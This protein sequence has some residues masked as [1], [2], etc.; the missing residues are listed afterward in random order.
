MKKILLIGDSVRM[1]YD[2]YVR[3]R[4]KGLAEVC[5]PPEN[6]RFTTYILRDLHNWTDALELYEADAVHWNAGLWDTLRIYGD[7]NLV[8][9]ETYAENID[10]I[11]RRIEFLFPTARQIF[12]TST[13]VIEEGYIPGFESRT[14]ADIETY[15]EIACRVLSGRAAINDLYAYL[16]DCHRDLHSDQTHFY[17]KEGTVLIGDRVCLSLC[18]ALGIDPRD[19]AP[20][21]MDSYRP[22]PSLPDREAYVAKGNI[23]VSATRAL[24]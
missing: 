13:P 5:F 21:D 1:G 10:R 11:Y 3:D 8:S 18:E 14:N 22:V 12:A 6:C 7:T 16:R 24:T 15:N 23:F 19:L 9:P 2:H 20:V 17:T 4:M